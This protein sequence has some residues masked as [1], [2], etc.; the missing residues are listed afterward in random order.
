[1]EAPTTSDIFMTVMPDQH[2]KDTGRVAF[3]E[4]CCHRPTLCMASSGESVIPRIKKFMLYRLQF[5]GHR[6]EPYAALA[7]A[8]QLHIAHVRLSHTTFCGCLRHF[9]LNVPP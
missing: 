5:L 8:L 4:G 7:L 9:L 2:D 1:M 3:L 6:I